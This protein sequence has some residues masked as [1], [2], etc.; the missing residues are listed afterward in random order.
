M[1]FPS[2]F[3]NGFLTDED[4]WNRNFFGGL[5]SRAATMKTDIKEQD[6]GYELSVELPGF[7]KDDLSVELK[8]GYLTVSAS[9][10]ENKDQKDE[11]GK[12][13]RRE[14]YQGS[15]RRSFYVGT[16]LTQDDVHAKFEDGVLKLT[17][18]KKTETPEQ[19]RKAIEIF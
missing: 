4:E 12:Y 11:D 5:T 10:T 13:I 14:R 6:N 7:A 2:V 19:E 1:L 16:N 3:S 18:P 15:C 8:D 17:I 9:K